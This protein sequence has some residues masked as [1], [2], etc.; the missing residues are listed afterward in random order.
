MVPGLDLAVLRLADAP[1]E[2][3]LPGPVFARLDRTHSGVLR[4]CT[5]IGQPL[6]QW[7]GRRPTGRRSGT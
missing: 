2:A 6:F 1:W 5:A 3:D 4:D 7:V